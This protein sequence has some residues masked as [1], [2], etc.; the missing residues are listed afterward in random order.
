MSLVFA[1]EPIRSISLHAFGDASSKGV[2]AAVYAVVEQES[3]MKQGLVAAKLRLSKQGLSIPRSQLLFDHMA[4]N[5]LTTS[6][7]R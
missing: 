6:M 4:V 3:G 5:L 7:M 1:R 2:H